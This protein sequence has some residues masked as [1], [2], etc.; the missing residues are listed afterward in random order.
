MASFSFARW[1]VCRA[2]LHHAARR[3]RTSHTCPSAHAAACCARSH[4]FGLR[5]HRHLCT[6]GWTRL[7]LR[8]GYAF[9]RA[10]RA[11]A[12]GT[13]FRA[14]GSFACLYRAA[15]R[16]RLRARSARARAP[17]AL[18]IPHA[19]TLPRALCA[20]ASR[21]LCVWLALSTSFS[22]FYAHA[23][24]HTPFCARALW[25]GLRTWFIA[26]AQNGGDERTHV[27]IVAHRALCARRIFYCAHTFFLRWVRAR[28]VLLRFAVH[29][30]L[31][32]L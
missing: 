28:S 29:I 26:R 24:A 10:W 19:R 18:R 22:P 12:V 32:Y 14:H 6:F 1:M 21:A 27:N 9:A 11:R 16:A 31:L 4:S 30:S 25:F 23:H 20:R 17:R 7:L 3:A 13:V 5:T 8:A 2:L 15:R